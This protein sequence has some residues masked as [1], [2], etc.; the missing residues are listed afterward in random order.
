MR[1]QRKGLLRAVRWQAQE[2]CCG[3]ELVVGRSPVQRCQVRFANQCGPLHVI[4]CHWLVVPE[5]ELLV[6]VEGWGEVVL[7][8]GLLM[9]C[10]FR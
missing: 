4:W 6:E 10:A 2:L 3:R 7:L 9:V 1:V 5:L 8:G